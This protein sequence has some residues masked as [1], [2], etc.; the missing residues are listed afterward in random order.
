M[1][2][3]L[4]NTAEMKVFCTFLPM[5]ALPWA[6][7]LS[8][9]DRSYAGTI[10]PDSA[11]PDR[12]LAK[13]L[14]EER[15]YAGV[16]DPDSATPDRTLA[17]AS[18]EERAA[19]VSMYRSTIPVQTENAEENTEDKKVEEDIDEDRIVS[20]YKSYIS[21]TPYQAFVVTCYGRACYRCGG[22]VLNKRWILT[23]AHCVVKKGR[24]SSDVEVT[25]GCTNVREATSSSKFQ[26]A[27]I[28]PH[29]YY[30]ER[31][32]KNDIALLKL[33]RDI[34]FSYKIKPA[35]LPNSYTNYQNKLAT[36]SGFGTIGYKLKSS[37]TIKKSSVWTVGINHSTCS[38]KFHGLDSKTQ[39]CAYELG[40]DTCQGDSGGPLVVNENG[41]N[42]VVGVVS[43]GHKCAVRN[44]AGVYTRVTG[45][46][47]WIQGYMSNSDWQCET[48]AAPTTR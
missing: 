42:I 22:T 24:T 8:V 9:E 45:Y 14:A 33:G 16:V 18:E 17:K 34:T 32:L 23:A 30:N 5:L 1:G 21:S 29:S 19:A 43:F 6:Q 36:I 13:T 11:I 40:T 37:D 2:S 38:P 27:R 48:A 12:R 26:A 39:M 15:N 31:T 28:I 44:Y 25:L 47:R 20:G 41:K 10:D 46:L 3:S 4:L 7:A 35:C